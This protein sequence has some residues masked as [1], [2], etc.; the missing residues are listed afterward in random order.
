MIDFV[1]WGFFLVEIEFASLLNQQINKKTTNQSIFSLLSHSSF[2]FYFQRP[3]PHLL[4]PDRQ[5]STVTMPTPRTPSHH[6]QIRFQEEKLRVQTKDKKDQSKKW[7][8]WSRKKNLDFNIYF[9]YSSLGANASAAVKI[10]L[11]EFLCERLER[12][13]KS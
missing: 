2:Y 4:N 11:K 12:A 9:F 3:Y 8:D 1:L 5:D 7:F 10:R 6:D 13:G